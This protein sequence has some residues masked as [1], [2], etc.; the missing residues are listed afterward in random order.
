[1]TDLTSCRI[2]EMY[3]N[4]VVILCSA[5]PSFRYRLKAV[6]ADSYVVKSPDLK[7]LKI[8]IKM[9]LG[10]TVPWLTEYRTN[11]IGM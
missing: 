10:V 8:K 1:M 4:K 2:S 9:A 7:Q 11:E 6:A 5:Y 3:Y